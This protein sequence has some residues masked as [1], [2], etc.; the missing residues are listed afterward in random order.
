[1]GGGCVARWGTRRT[2]VAFAWA[3]SL[4]VALYA[5]VASGWL[6]QPR[7]PGVFG[8]WAALVGFEHWVSALGS[9]ALFSAMMDACR[10]DHEGTDYSLQA[11]W[12]VVCSGLAGVASGGSAAL[13]GHAGH[14]A[15][16]ALACA[17]VAIAVLRV[18]PPSL[19]RA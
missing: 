13:L 6:V 15:L 7:M 19:V 1:M 11:S 12:V 9:V 5:V 14:F 3:G 8:V 10:V 18:R 16:G 4:S 17:A 2:L